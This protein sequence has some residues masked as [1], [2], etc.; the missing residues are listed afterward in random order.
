MK[1][2]KYKSYFRWGLEELQRRIE[3]R[4]EI[5]YQEED[6][7]EEFIYEMNER[8]CESPNENLI[9]MFLCAVE[10]GEYTR[11]L[12][13]KRKEQQTENEPKRRKDKFIGWG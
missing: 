5:G 6:V 4:C 13:T 9:D 7:I 3:D 2:D 11:D 1:I 10:A 8:V 12:Y